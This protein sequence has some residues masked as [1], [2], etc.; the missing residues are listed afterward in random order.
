MNH[1][2]Q[3]IVLRCR[4]SILVQMM[5]CCLVSLVLLVMLTCESF[6]QMSEAQKWDLTELSLQELMA[7]EIITIGR[8]QQKLTETPA[9]VYV[10]TSEDIRRSGA[11]C[12]PEALRMVPGLQVARTGVDR[13]AI[14]SRGFNGNDF[15]SNKLLVLM[16][17]RTVYNAVYSGMY[18]NV[19]D[20]LLE[21][22]AR[23]EVIRGPGAS[24]WGANAVN[25]IIN[26][27][28]KPAVERQGPLAS[29]IAGTEDRFIGAA[30]YGGAI[31]ETAHYSAFAKYSDRDGA[32]AP[33]GEDREDEWQLSLAG[34]R[35][36]WAVTEKDELTVQSGYYNGNDSYMIADFEVPGEGDLSADFN[37]DFN[38]DYTET[39]SGFNVLSRW[40]HT[41]SAQSEIIAQGYFYHTDKD[42]SRYDERVDTADLDLQHRFGLG[43]RQEIMWGLGY[44]TINSFLGSSESVTFD[45]KERRDE[46]LSCFVQDDITVLRDR[47]SLILGSKFERND[48]TDWETQP[49]ARLLWTPYDAHTLWAAVSKAV[50]I[51]TRYEHDALIDSPLDVEGFDVDGAVVT[52][53]GNKDMASEEVVAYEAGYRYH[54]SDR[55]GLDLA[56]Y[57][58]QYDNLRSWRWNI[59][60]A[61][62]EDPPGRW[63][64]P[65]ETINGME[66]ETYG[67]EL[68]LDWRPYAWWRLEGTYSIIKM[69]IREEYPN[70]LVRVAD[71]IEG[72]TPEQQYGVRSAMNLPH[73]IEL[74]L[75]LRYV[76]GLSAVFYKIPAYW[77]LDARIGW[78]FRE[79]SFDLVGQNLFDDSHPEF[80]SE[81]FNPPH[82]EI[83]RGVYFRV[84]WRPE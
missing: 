15:F 45:P 73:D 32:L 26:I 75:W 74:D 36:D 80:F 30:R 39:Y 10:I 71:V 50:R 38:N 21:D 13:W 83:Q 34:G 5:H 81:M 78:R 28:T 2:K 46:L 62:Y 4:Q 42:F 66:G 52:I 69:D 20:T 1:F 48:Y 8:R 35:F 82:S 14:S 24:L 72:Q 37:N 17:G 44:R 60:D 12:I 11:T 7:I 19:Q 41:F 29:V 47:L 51:P 31:G 68:V 79:F 23:I 70:D 43:R 59:A 55:F 56:F 53:Y 27:V 16:D 57:Y 3:R 77:T 64:A 33:T 9:A 40:Q 84:T 25:G 76:D 49:N 22:I 63:V 18:W 54:P 61:F 58:N 65:A 67:G 6:A